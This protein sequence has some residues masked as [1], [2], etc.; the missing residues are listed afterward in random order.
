MGV[1]AHRLIRNLKL[2]SKTLK[3]DDPDANALMNQPMRAP[4]K[5]GI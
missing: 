4:W 3:F 1:T 5:F 2:E